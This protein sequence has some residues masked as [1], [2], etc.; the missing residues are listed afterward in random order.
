VLGVVYE[1]RVSLSSEQT[2]ELR[3]I[4]IKLRLSDGA[5][6]I[7]FQICLLCFCYISQKVLWC[8]RLERLAQGV[9]LVNED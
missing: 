5:G 1:E 8:A 2:G 3:R 9:M 7:I 6:S 4:E